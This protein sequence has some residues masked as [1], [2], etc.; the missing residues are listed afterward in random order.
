MIE[1][2]QIWT[3]VGVN[4]TLFAAAIAV[5][6]WMRTESRNDYRHLHDIQREDRKDLLMLIEA[7]KDEVKAIRDEMKDFHNRM[8]AIEERNKGK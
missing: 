6:I 7:I 8:C 5:V 3:L 2:A 4:A 1:W